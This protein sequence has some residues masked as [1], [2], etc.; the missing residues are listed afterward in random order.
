MAD[1]FPT[2]Q[3]RQEHI[4]ALIRE[5]DGYQTDGNAERAAEVTAELT[6]LGAEAKPKQ[7]RAAKRPASTAKPQKR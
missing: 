1:E 3:L 6:R 5:R 7:K 4:A 2:D